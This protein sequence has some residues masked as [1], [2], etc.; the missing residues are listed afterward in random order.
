MCFCGTL[1]KIYYLLSHSHS[2]S[3]WYKVFNV[4]I[5]FLQGFFGKIFHAFLSPVLE[6]KKKKNHT[7]KCV[8]RLFHPTRE[9]FHSIKTGLRRIANQVTKSNL[10]YCVE[11]WSEAPNQCPIFQCDDYT[12]TL[13]STEINPV[14][15]HQRWING[16]KHL[17]LHQQPPYHVLSSNYL[18]WHGQ[19]E[20]Q[21]KTI[22]TFQVLPK[23]SFCFWK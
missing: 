23:A 17:L 11:I 8:Q 15:T 2:A 12:A 22:I 10:I 7:L 20:I 16:I 13:F 5:R 9:R 14:T 4:F 21:R 18:N 1:C 3:C 6:R 19:K